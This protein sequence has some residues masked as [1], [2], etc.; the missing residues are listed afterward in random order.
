MV[1][2]HTRGS[3]VLSNAIGIVK[4]LTLVF[5]GLT[6]LVCLGGHTRVA[7]PTRNFRNAFT[8][9]DGGVAP[10]PYGLTNALYRIIFSYSGYANA[11]N[12]VNE[13]RNPIPT[14][15]RNGFLSLLIVTVLYL[16]ANIA[17]FAAV[18][19]RDLAA[20][21]QTAATLF[22]TSVFGE[23]RAVQGLN[24]LIALSSFGN[25]IAVLLGQSRLIRETGRQGALPWTRFWVSTKPFGT[26][27]GPYTVKWALT[28]LVL[29]ALPQGDAFNFGKSE[30]K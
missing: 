27:L 20:A 29:L 10:E 28:L 16:L 18:D 24:F 23:S 30:N 11:F 26:P 19:L 21:K 14:L 13:V 7:D 1:S 4:V 5:I 6:G 12:V 22:F 25:L 2:F 3:Y 15:K 17:F 9:F 8:H